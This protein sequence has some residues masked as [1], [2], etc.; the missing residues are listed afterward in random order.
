[1]A[2]QFRRKG[3]TVGLD[4]FLLAAQD[5]VL[6]ATLVAVLWYAR[7]TQHLVKQGQEQRARADRA[8]VLIQRGAENGQQE[9]FLTNVLP[10]TAINVLYRSTRFG[11]PPGPWKII[12]PIGGNR[13]TLPPD[14]LRHELHRWA[15]ADL[16]DRPTFSILTQSVGGDWSLVEQ[17]IESRGAVSSRVADVSADDVNEASLVATASRL[18]L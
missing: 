17:V 5:G 4:T 8:K 11:A 1:M 13:T 14:E 3:A 18:D 16:A 15:G 10:G 7:L 6:L 9:Y 12:G 2:R